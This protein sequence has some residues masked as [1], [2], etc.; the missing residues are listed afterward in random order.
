MITRATTAAN[1]ENLAAGFL[2]RVVGRYAGTRLGRQEK[3][4]AN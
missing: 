1:E 2:E 4:W 3:S